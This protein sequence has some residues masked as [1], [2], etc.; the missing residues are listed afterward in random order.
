M[1]ISRLSVT[2]GEPLDHAVR[3][4][5]SSG[6]AHVLV[7]EDDYPVGIVSTLDIARAAGGV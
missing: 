4:M 1:Y 5:A 2:P 7:L 3:V 6:V